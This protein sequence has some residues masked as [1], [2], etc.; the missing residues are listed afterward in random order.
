MEWLGGSE[1]N[2]V[3][4]KVQG[5]IVVTENEYSRWKAKVSKWESKQLRDVEA[6]PKAQAIVNDLVGS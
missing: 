4:M 3:E 5:R 6:D 2:S 1:W